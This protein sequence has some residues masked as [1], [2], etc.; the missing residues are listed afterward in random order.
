MKKIFSIVLILAGLL[1]LGACVEIRNTPPSIN[2]AQTSIT[3]NFGDE[4]DPL[5]GITAIDDKDGDLTTEIELV[6]F[7]PAWLTDSRG[8]QYSYTI[9]VEDSEG[10]P[11]SISVQLVI[12]GS[13]QQTVS[14]QFVQEAQTYYIGSRPYDPLR[15]VK[16]IDTLEIDADGNPLDL[17]DQ[18]QIIGLPSL[19]R[20]GRFSYQLTVENELGAN[21]TRT[22]SLTVKP[23]VNYIPTALTT[24]D[25]TIKLWHSN[26]STIEGRLNKYAEDFKVLYPNITVEII[27][28]GDNYDQLRQ[29][30]I[31]AIKGGILP[32]IVQGYPDHVAEYITN[33]AVIS[34]G[35][36]IDHP[37]WGFDTEDEMASFET[38]L[39]RYRNEN[40]Q[41]TSDGEFYSLPF[42]KSTEVMIYNKDVVDAL[43]QAGHFTEMPKT[44]Q[45]LFAVADKFEEVAPTYINQYAQIL[46]LTNV[47]R[48]DA[49]R[50]FIPYSYDSEDNAFITLLRQWGGSYTGI[51]SD[52]KGV[53]LYDSAEARA[54]LTYFNQNRDKFTIPSNWRANYASDVFTKGQTFMTI[55]STGGAYYNT[56]GRYNGQ[57]L[58]EFEVA[59]I[60]YNKD[61]PQFATAI[62]QGTNMS[63]TSSGTDQQKLASWL[64]LK[65]LNSHEVQLD[66]ALAT[67]Y[68]PTRESVY[69]SNEYINFMNGFDADNK[70]LVDEMLMR[71][72]AAR[73]AAEQAPI[74]FF[75]QAFVGSSTIRDA[76]GVAFQRVIVPNETDT[77]E[78]ALQYAISEA[79]RILGN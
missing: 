19:N 57:P 23:A 9:Y 59:P 68:Q 56:P 13:V 8:G 55:G 43:I 2:G 74:L 16:A 47:E 50:L 14:L 44:W 76:V 77:V 26:G 5:A 22:V 58:F 21:A 78:N 52:R 37:T 35:P 32:N 41:Y 51:N 12:V 27:K 4:F 7:N 40:S 28:N 71:S 42:N 24:E 46:G 70:P 20:P 79:R 29:N 54:M 25:I 45:D 18:I 36:Y 1:A 53:A 30:T 67:G 15:G 33:N 49:L 38:I 6:G 66:F 60:P 61:L 65:F 73:A 11:A 31:S 72:K 34:V 75:D 48:E 3:I 63:L 69:V 39:W 64:F 62:Q 17:T 10:L